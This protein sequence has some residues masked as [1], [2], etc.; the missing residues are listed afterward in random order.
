MTLDNQQENEAIKEEI[1]KYIVTNE[2]KHSSAK[3]LGQSEESSEK[4]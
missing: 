2:G 4:K 1:Q 3:S